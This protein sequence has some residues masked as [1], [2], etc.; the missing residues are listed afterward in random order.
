MV[1]IMPYTYLSCKDSY[2]SP[3]YAYLC[4]FNFGNNAD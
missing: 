4:M 2:Y 1:V 3:K